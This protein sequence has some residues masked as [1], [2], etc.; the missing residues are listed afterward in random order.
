MGYPI[1]RPAVAMGFHLI[2]SA[3]AEVVDG[4]RF[5][6]HLHRHKFESACP[7]CHNLCWVLLGIDK[8]MVEKQKIV[9]R[10]FHYLFLSCFLWPQKIA[11]HDDDSWRSR[12]LSILH[13]HCIC[14][15]YENGRLNRPCWGGYGQPGNSIGPPSIPFP[16]L[17]IPR[18]SSMVHGHVGI[19]GLHRDAQGRCFFSHPKIQ[20]NP[21]KSSS[22]T[23]SHEVWWSKELVSWGAAY[24]LGPPVRGPGGL[25]MLRWLA[26]DVWSWNVALPRIQV[27]LL[28]TWQLPPWQTKLLFYPSTIQNWWDSL[29]KS[30]GLIVID[31]SMAQSH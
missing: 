9:S 3:L 7:L 28:E 22:F 15:V 12:V 10:G 18:W 26:T 29:H 8:L 19:V 16:M 2:S 24:G 13:L 23:A 21:A 14:V 31:P 4:M 20:Q 30:Q 6:V 11:T 25:A 1:F 17:R 27:M 5:L